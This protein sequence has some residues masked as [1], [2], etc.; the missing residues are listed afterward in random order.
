M[1]TKFYRIVTREVFERIPFDGILGE[2]ETQR[3]S[4]DGTHFVLERNAEF[5]INERWLSHGETLEL[6]ATPE[7]SLPEQFADNGEENQSKHIP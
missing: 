5:P 7:W 6:M 4:I 3:Q 1:D 2:R